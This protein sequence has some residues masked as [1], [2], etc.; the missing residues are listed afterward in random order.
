MA[1]SEAQVNLRRPMSYTDGGTASS[2]VATLTPG[3]SLSIESSKLPSGGATCS[4][5]P[6]PSPTADECSEIGSSQR[7]HPGCHV[8]NWFAG[9]TIAKAASDRFGVVCE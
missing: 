3:T 2:I 6:A 4:E 9:R 8:S 7:W 5:L 1:I